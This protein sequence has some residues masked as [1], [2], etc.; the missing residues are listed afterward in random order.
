MVVKVCRALSGRPSPI[1]F[2]TM[3]LLPVDSITLM[4]RT[5]LITGYTI[6]MDDRALVL[7]YLDTNTPSTMVYRDMTTIIMVVGRA[8][9][10]SDPN[11]NFL[12][13]E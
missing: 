12:D 13:N 2:A 5:M 10:S 6:L 11:V 1:F 9:I 4:P 8:N 3:A 7:T